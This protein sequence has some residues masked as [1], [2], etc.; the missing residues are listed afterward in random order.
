MVI[1]TLAYVAFISGV[2]IWR[3]I[4]VEPDYLLAIFVPIAV[5]S[6]KFVRFL[7]D[8][9]PFVVIFLAW[10]A[11]RGLAAKDGIAPHVGDLASIEKTL[12]FGNVP[13]QVMQ[14]WFSGSTL[15]LVAVGATVVYFCHFA[16]PLVVGLV[17]WLRD[18][19]QYLRFTTALMGMAMVAFVFF[20]LV[21]TAPPWYAEIHGGG[22]GGFQK[23]ISH[24]LPSAVGPY[25]QS[26]NPNQTAAW[27]SLHAAFPFLGFLALR[28][29][30]PRASYLALA[31]SVIVWFSIV[32]LGE[33]YVIDAIGGVALAAG[34]W[35]V[36]M[37]FAVPRVSLLQ[38]SVARENV[39][40][41]PAVA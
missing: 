18:R 35:W 29:V 39:L 19:T 32:F 13:T 41:E 26:L 12:F 10:E 3:G 16:M 30:Y 22:I 23:L 15:Q 28:R 17:L 5:L 2:M 31:W 27:P 20:L 40:P 4:S 34:S 7:R 37:R 14:S 21:P 38:H 1:F 25:Y 11:M 36:L 24:T 33:H 8:W 6:G 9:I